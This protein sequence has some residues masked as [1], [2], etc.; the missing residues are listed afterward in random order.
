VTGCDQDTNCN[1]ENDNDECDFYYGPCPVPE[2]AP[3]HPSVETFVAG[4]LGTAF[5]L[6]ALV[7]YRRRW[8]EG[9]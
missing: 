1:C 4:Q 6:A 2:P 8:P 7:S 9:N 5:G 3:N